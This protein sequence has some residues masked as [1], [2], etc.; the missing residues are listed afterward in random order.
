MSHGQKS[1]T[2][3]ESGSMPTTIFLRG[4]QFS[5]ADDTF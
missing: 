5:N 1:L 2:L 3:P 4:I